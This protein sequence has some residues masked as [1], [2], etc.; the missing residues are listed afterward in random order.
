MSEGEAGLMCDCWQIPLGDR[1]ILIPRTS[2]LEESTAN[3]GSGEF[4]SSI[5]S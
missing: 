3:Q 4:T 2:N 1:K 5:Q